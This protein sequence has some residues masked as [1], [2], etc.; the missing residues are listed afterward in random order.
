MKWSEDAVKSKVVSTKSAKVVAVAYV[1][2][3]VCVSTPPPPPPPTS[4]W[5]KPLVGTTGRHTA[6]EVPPA[7]KVH[8]STIPELYVARPICGG[9]G[10]L[11]AQV[12]PKV[13][14]RR[15]VEL[16]PTKTRVEIPWEAYPHK[17]RDCGTYLHVLFRGDTTLIKWVSQQG[18]HKTTAILLGG[19]KVKIK[20]ICSDGS[21]ILGESY[22]LPAG[23]VP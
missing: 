12:L 1:P 20:D 21:V 8:A 2:P 9:D 13:G 6:V 4:A 19:K 3:P 22:P 17:F 15:F 14:G 18:K 7:D 11:T 10:T 23:T 16:L 5:A